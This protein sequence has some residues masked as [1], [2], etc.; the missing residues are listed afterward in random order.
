MI[1]DP[2]DLELT[3]TRYVYSFY[4]TGGDFRWPFITIIIIY[5]AIPTSFT[6]SLL[7]GALALFS[8]SLGKLFLITHEPRLRNSS[9][10]I[11]RRHWDVSQLAE[12]ER[13]IMELKVYDL[14]VPPQEDLPVLSFSLQPR[15]NYGITI[16]PHST[17]AMLHLKNIY[18][19]LLLRSCLKH[20]AYRPQN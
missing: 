4:T 8:P 5:D 19:G 12:T 6:Y 13:T 10:L 2:Q 9:R 16:T 20:L 17:M 15:R 14:D 3:R 11:G 1:C 7:L 18:D